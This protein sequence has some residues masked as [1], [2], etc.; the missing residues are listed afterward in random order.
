MPNPS[1]PAHRL[2]A[3]RPQIVEK[4]WGRE[5]IY[6]AGQRFAGKLLEVRGGA[7]LSLHVHARKHETF[8]VQRG[9]ALLWAGDTADTLER[10]RLGPGDT[11]DLP[12]GVVHR[13]EAVVDC[14]LLEASSPELDDLIRLDD[15]YGRHHGD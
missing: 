1:P 14:V 2:R 12:P 8:Y 11:V 13:L 5:V 9:E 10:L 7:R 15:D 4:P 3:T 6:A